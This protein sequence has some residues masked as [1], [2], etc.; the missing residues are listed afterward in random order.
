MSN[1]T[2]EKGASVEYAILDR[3]VHI[4]AGAKVGGDRETSELTV[5]AAGKEVLK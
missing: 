3:D 2:I 5:I 4:H 1:V